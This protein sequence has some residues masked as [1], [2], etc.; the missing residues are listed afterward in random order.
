[1]SD[2]KVSHFDDADDLLHD[3]TGFPH[4]RESLLWTAPLPDE[5][6]LI[7]AYAWRDA[8]TGLYGRF[9]SISGDGGGAP[10]IPDSAEDL[11]LEG[12]DLDDCVIGGLR[13][14]QPAPLQ[15]AE[16]SFEN[17]Q[18]PYQAIFD[19]LHEP[20]SWHRTKAVVHRGRPRTATSNPAG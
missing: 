11:E 8:D 17:D 1:M 2:H 20:F 14:R 9:V 19:G 6:L 10:I 16:I 15:T 4:G 5:G 13:L 3:I 12:E 18:L 7:F